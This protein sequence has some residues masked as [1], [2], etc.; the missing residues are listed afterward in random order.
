[1][2]RYLAAA[3]LDVTTV[4]GDVSTAGCYFD[5]DYRQQVSWDQPLL[6]GYVYEV[7]ERPLVM[8]YSPWSWKKRA[9][10]WMRQYRPHV[11]WVH[12]WGTAFAL[13]TLLAAHECG[14]PIFLRGETHLKGLR[15][16][17]LWRK[18]HKSL[19][20]SLFTQVDQF[21][22]IGSTNAAFYRAYGVEE[23]RIALVPYVTDNFH[24]QAACFKAHP[25]R[26]TLRSELGLSSGRPILL[27]VGRLSREKGLN[28]LLQAFQS[29]GETERPYLLLAGEGPLSRRLRSEVPTAVA[30]DVRFLGFVRHSK[31]PALYDLCDALVLPSLHE[32]WGMVVNEAMNAGKPIIVS[33]RVG[34]ARDL[35]IQGVNG[36]I[37]PAG[38]ACA[39]ADAV[40]RCASDKEKRIRAGQASL[41]IISF[42]GVEKALQGL[43]DALKNIKPNHL[44][45]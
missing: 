26:E 5:P 35:V 23:K 14:L 1:M 27:F 45:P 32:P 30:D 21:L 20:S 13:G 34:C 11:V 43:C 4:Y 24:F 44:F 22:A 39:L 36:E 9:L 29:L 15:G 33:D 10:A 3:G 25:N 37:F 2:L 40:R 8:T 28:T 12:G 42:W 18:I 16:S 17:W 31:L 38:D 19:F 41:S 6:D 7:L